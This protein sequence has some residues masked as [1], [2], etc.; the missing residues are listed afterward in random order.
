MA[1]PR[2]RGA[3]G[4]LLLF[5]IKGGAVGWAKARKRRAHHLSPARCCMVGTLR[6]AHPTDH[7]RG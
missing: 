4:G 5:D 1:N 3:A 2:A 7:L 6:F